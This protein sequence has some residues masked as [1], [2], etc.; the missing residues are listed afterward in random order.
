MKEKER[1]QDIKLKVLE[2]VL[3]KT[4]SITPP[5]TILVLATPL[6]EWILGNNQTLQTSTD[7]K[8]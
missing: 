1:E 7:D 6:S 2:M 3:E 4:Q 5:E 8:E